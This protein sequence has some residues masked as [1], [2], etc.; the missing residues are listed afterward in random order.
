MAKILLFI[1]K[2][3]LNKSYEG[4]N[5]YKMQQFTPKTVFLVKNY[6]KIPIFSSNH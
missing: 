2:I 5:D 6:L 3:A 1:D 4:N